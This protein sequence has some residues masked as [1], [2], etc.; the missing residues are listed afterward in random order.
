MTSLR[1]SPVCAAGIASGAGAEMRHA[2]GLRCLP[3]WWG[4][5]FGLF[6]A[7][8]YVVMRSLRCACTQGPSPKLQL[9]ERV[10]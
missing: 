10:S 9:E 8:F 5:L 1:S 6:Y 2:M 3:G 4:D 7:V